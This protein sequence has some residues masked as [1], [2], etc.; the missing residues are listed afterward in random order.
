MVLIKCYE[1]NNNISSS[2]KSC[3]NCGAPRIRKR[4]SFISKVKT[5]IAKFEDKQPFFFASIAVIIISIAII[6]LG[7]Y[8]EYS[9]SYIFRNI[10]FSQHLEYN[11]FE[12]I[13]RILADELGSGL[14][15]GLVG[16]N[17]VAFIIFLIKGLK[18]ASS[19]YS[20]QHILFKLFFFPNY[21]ILIVPYR[22]LKFVMK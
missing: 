7:S 19:I 2:A 12:S 5:S 3:P 1:C 14:G 17:F 4:Y 16:A 9:N 11:L 6:V 18:H 13:P 15:Y 22:I 21:L 8:I 10:S 20:K